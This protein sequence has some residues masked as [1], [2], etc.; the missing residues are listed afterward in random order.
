M[1]RK[2]QYQRMTG[3]YCMMTSYG[4]TQFYLLITRKT[5]FSF[6]RNYREQVISVIQISQP[7][8]FRAMNQSDALGKSNLN[9]ADAK[10]SEWKFVF[11]V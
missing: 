6:S 1:T 10:Y 11:C 7:L 4:V 3:Y 9:L 2:A 5:W 8:L